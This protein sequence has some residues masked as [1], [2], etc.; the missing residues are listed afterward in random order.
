MKT[1]VQLTPLSDSEDY[2]IAYLT[3]DAENAE[4]IDCNASFIELL[5]GSKESIKGLKLYELLDA[6][7]QSE[8]QVEQIVS[9]Q[10]QKALDRGGA[11]A[12]YTIM[13]NGQIKGIGKLHLH[14]IVNTNYLSG[15][16]MGLTSL[17]KQLN[18]QV[19]TKL[20]SQLEESVVLADSGS[21]L[22]E[23]T[24]VIYVNQAFEQRTGYTLQ[25]IHEQSIQLLAGPKTDRQ[26][27]SDIRKARKHGKSIN[28]Q[29]QFYK[30]SGETY[31]TD[32]QVSPIYNQSG[33]IIYWVFIGRDV[34]NLVEQQKEL[35]L[36]ASAFN[37]SIDGLG[38]LDSNEKF[39]HVNPAHADIYGYD[40]PD[41]LIGKSWR[42][43]Y[44]EKELERFEDS[45]LPKLHKQSYWRGEAKGLRKDGST[46]DQEVT[47]TY[48]EDEGI[49]CV[50]RDITHQKELENKLK[51]HQ[52]NLERAEEMAGIGFWYHDLK[53]DDSGMSDG[54]YR[55]LGL[56]PDEYDQFKYENYFDR[57]HED[58]Q[59]MFQEKTSK[60]YREGET[61]H[62]THRI[63][64]ADNGKISYIED[65]GEIEYD[66][67]G[68][69]KRVFGTIRDITEIKEKEQKIRQNYQLFQQLFDNTPMGKVFMEPEGRILDVNREFTD[70]FGYSKEESIGNSLYD[71]LFPE[72]D[73]EL[74]Q[75]TIDKINEG[76]LIIRDTIRITRHG[77]K[78]PVLV[79]GVPIEIDG[80]I[81]RAFAI[82]AD[83]KELKDKEESLRESVAEKQVLLQEIHHRVKNNLAIVSGLLDLQSGSIDN[84]QAQRAL[85]GSQMRIQSMAKVH[86]ALYKSESLS[87]V[88]LKEYLHELIG[89][90]EQVYD[91]EDKSVEIGFNVM[92]DITLS[93]NQAV[94]AAMLLNE[95][96]TNAYQHAFEGLEKGYIQV[97]AKHKSSQIHISIEDNGVGIKEENFRKSKSLG[98]TIVQ[99]LCKQLDAQ[100]NIESAEG[101]RFEI[102]FNANEKKGA[103]STL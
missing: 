22:K 72:E 44:E 56:N 66:G 20:F 99:T 73:E 89:S 12:D 14:P 43:L 33:D 98:A 96:I 8:A 36:Q 39:I 81:K 38:I 23:G 9:E 42:T 53:S 27:L 71:L 94:P 67:K 59:E 95:L 10:I 31:W 55:I 2:D 69:R 11:S 78:H 85:R 74:I 64:R 29:V 17:N 76:D 25:E 6:S 51:R 7:A 5:D 75:E 15:H 28:A 83:I 92:S 82:Y 61:F 90:I 57:V 18:W 87:N 97:N 16:I 54:A 102:I 50:V 62:F 26:T 45:V 40:N 86:D 58:D 24:N 37:S 80:E 30:K 49:I 100:L 19:I 91:F 88:S 13:E 68:N 32:I 84:P 101:T 63:R 34:T 3:I 79:T 52:E 93:I 48:V 46:F 41:E 103:Q 35:R 60:L 77:E 4:I 21:L 47:L 70:M 1:G 65:Q